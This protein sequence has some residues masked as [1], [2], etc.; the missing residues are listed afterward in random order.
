MANEKQVKKAKQILSTVRMEKGLSI[1][2]LLR[3]T[4]PYY[5]NTGRD[6]IVIKK[7]N[8]K[9]RTKGLHYAVTAV[10]V[11][12]SKRHA[13][14]PHKCSIIG[15]DKGVS[16][17]SRQKRVHVSCDCEDF[18]FTW[19]YSLMTWGAAAIKY[20]NGEP[21]VV[22]NPGNVAGACKHLCAVMELVLERNE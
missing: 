12:A 4:P 3:R 5:K 6:D 9:A 10:C 13:A 18:C 21:A 17:L 15:L 2:G 16:K 20:S 11:S 19:E 14:V 7:Y 1:K 8:P 22:K